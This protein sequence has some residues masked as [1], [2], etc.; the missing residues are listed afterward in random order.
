MNKRAVIAG[1]C[2]MGLM[3][4]LPAPSRASAPVVCTW[5][6]NPTAA[7][8]TIKIEPGLTFTPAARPLRLVA[9]G[10]AECTDGFTGTVMFEGVIHAGGNCLVQIFEGR[11]HGLPGV[12]TFFGPGVTPVVHELLYDRDGRVVGS[13]QPQVLSGIGQGPEASDCSTRKGV[14]D[15]VFSSTIELYR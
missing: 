7:T 12:A 1:V 9:T 11:V 13:D 15:G 3:G 10:P 8:G 2:A 14:T 6:G 5:G 4:A